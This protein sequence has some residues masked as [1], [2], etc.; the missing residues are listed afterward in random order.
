MFVFFHILKGGRSS[1]KTFATPTYEDKLMGING[2]MGMIERGSLTDKDINFILDSGDS[3]LI[4]KLEK[5]YEKEKKNA[6]HVQSVYGK[7]WTNK[8]NDG[9]L[10]KDTIV[11][12]PATERSTKES[13]KNYEENINPKS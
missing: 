12:D 13:I 1:T 10:F 2:Q 5:K 4:N 9:N 8:D 3:K 7:E 6:D 11:Y